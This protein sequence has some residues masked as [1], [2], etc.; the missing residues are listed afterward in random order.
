MKKAIICLALLFVATYASAVPA[1]TPISVDAFLSVDDVTVAHLEQFR[2]AV[3][4]EANNKQGGLIQPNTISGDRLVAATRPEVRWDEAFNNWVYT[5][6]L[7]PTSAS[8][9]ATTTA[10]VAYINGNRVSKDATAHTYTA[11]KWTFVD[12]SDQGTYTYDEEAIGTADPAI[13]A[14]SMRMARVS[15]DGTTVGAVR[16]DRILA[17]SLDGFQENFQRVGM[18]CHFT[19]PDAVIID[20]GVVYHGTTRIKKASDTTLGLGVGGDWADG[21]RATSTLAFI[22]VNPSGLI[23]FTTTAPTLHDIAGNTSG[24][25]RYSD[26]GGVKWRLL[27][28]F[29]MNGLGSG[30]FQ[31]GSYGTFPDGQVNMASIS[32]DNAN[33]ITGIATV[34]MDGLTSYFYSSGN[35]LRVELGTPIFCGTD[36]EY[37]TIAISVDDVC[38]QGDIGFFASSTGTMDG[39]HASGVIQV[40]QGLHT[41]EGKW[42]MAN[43]AYHATSCYKNVGY[44]ILTV[45]EL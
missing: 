17:I 24:T 8:L 27:G 23:Q 33:T 35:P 9:A 41:V 12:L 30:N 10:G 16:D 1:A 44:R 40:P 15:T 31:E 2:T 42:S 13:T 4:N 39:P 20:P 6:L 11:S 7:P 29:R 3:V 37:G 36:G 19:T 14:S 43:A 38:V 25:L 18:Y 32:Q 5:G 34:V 28:W 22:A 21:G 45:Q 26:I